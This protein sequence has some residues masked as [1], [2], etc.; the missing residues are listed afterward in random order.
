MTNK[1]LRK[2]LLEKLDITQQAL[3]LRVQKIKKQ[4]SMTTEDATYVIAQQEGLILDK[5]LSR[6]EL[7]RVRMLHQQLPVGNTK[8]EV[9][10]GIR[11][12]KKEKSDSDER[13]IVI[14]KEFK[15]NDPIL[16]ES[17]LS[18]A[19]QMAAVYPLLYILEN[20]IREV[21]D[22][23]MIKQYGEKWFD[24]EAPK[25]L[26]DKVDERM[27]DESKD[28]WHQKRGSRPIDYLDLNQL[29]ALM[30]RIE[31]NVV[32]SIIPSFEW[33]N[34]RVEEVYKSRCVLCHMNPLD[35]DNI[36]AVK[37][38]LKQWQKQIESKKKLIL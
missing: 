8:P 29:P 9:Q 18:D 31:K 27:A 34:Q 14:G 36:Q 37:L 6:D 20:S 3:S 13:T 22:R 12:R 24:S 33:F 32:P 21:I 15:G 17:K 1:K 4:I 5:Y 11:A 35:Q 10:K 26:R 25:G 28:S 30:R 2:A 16:P 7:D 19:K 23:I 38:R